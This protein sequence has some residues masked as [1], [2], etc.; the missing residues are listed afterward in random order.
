MYSLLLLREGI[1]MKKVAVS[2][3]CSS[4]VFKEVGQDES[5]Y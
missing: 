1:L 2:I 4:R 3:V 5:K